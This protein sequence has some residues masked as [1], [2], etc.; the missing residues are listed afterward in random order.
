MV[1]HCAT[2]FL[3]ETGAWIY[4]QISPLTRWRPI[5]FTQEAANHL[6]FP[7]EPLVDAGDWPL[8]KRVANRLVR[9][10]TGEYP[11]YGRQ[12]RRD[13]VDLIHAHFGYQ[14]CRCLRAQRQTGL[15]MIT[16][17][18][19]A[20]ATSF[21]RQP[22]WRRRYDVLFEQGT[23]F[24]AEGSAMREQ[25]LSLGCPDERLIVHHLG[26]DTAS[27]RW[28]ARQPTLAPQ[29]LMC[30]SF[31]EKKGYDDGLRAIGLALARLGRAA[32]GVK[33][34]LIGDG[35]ERPR[36]EVAITEA[37]LS[38]RVEMVGMLPYAQVVAYLEQSHILLQPSR[39][40]SD[41]DTE[42]G[43]PVILLDAQ[44]AGVPI[45]AT[46]HADIPEYV[47]D[48]VSGLLAQERDVE[49][50]A[51]HIQRLL[52][53]PERWAT[54]GEAGRRHVEAG[55]DAVGQCARLETIYDAVAAGDGRQIGSTPSSSGSVSDSAG[56]S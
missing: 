37:G 51:Q 3:T 21:A 24:V 16:T 50:L 2:P 10:V 22:A 42:G 53:E 30:G 56:L 45:I 26:V 54:M 34:V 8:P 27:I 25:L 18:Y 52:G 32:K 55:Y 9:R 38:G 4:H 5:V 12:M 7:V 39:V 41:G 6:Q 20:D 35:P 17:F 49:G 1:A 48:G 15:P 28:T 43:A 47:Q 11:F 40:A 14:G 13:G 19:G 23:L 31:R 46:R 36:I 29:I 44:A 33:I